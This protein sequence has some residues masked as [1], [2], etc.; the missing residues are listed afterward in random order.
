MGNINFGKKVNLKGLDELINEAGKK[1]SIRVGIIGEKAYEKAEGTNLTNAQLGAA[2]EFGATINNPGGQ[3]YYINST[4]GMAVFVSKKSL[5]GQY[6]ISKGQVTKPHTITLPTRSFL[7]MPLLSSEGKKAII[8]G[9]LNDKE[10]GPDRKY[11]GKTYEIS[12]ELT[13]FTKVA[14][15]KKEINVEYKN[16][17]KKHIGKEI[18]EL[19]PERIAEAALERVQEAFKTGGFGKWAPIT[20]YSMKHRVNSNNGEQP[21]NDTGRLYKSI[22]AEVKR[23]N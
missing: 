19:L 21:L 23:I 4:T 16:Y 12:E 18:I 6:L 2:H 17:L 15:S 13:E 10:I 14:G 8:Q 3:P 22:T 9:V 20:K 1:Y 7:R 5:F 11:T